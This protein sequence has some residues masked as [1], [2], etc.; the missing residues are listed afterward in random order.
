MPKQVPGV[1]LQTGA[2]P[3]LVWVSRMASLTLGLLSWGE[4]SESWGEKTVRATA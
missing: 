2:L 4:R 3:L 1:A